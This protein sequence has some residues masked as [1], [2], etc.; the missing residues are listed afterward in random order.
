M[1]TLKITTVSHFN[2][3]LLIERIKEN[4]EDY[5]YKICLEKVVMSFDEIKIRSLK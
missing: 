2:K 5:E 1:Q 4:F 3:G